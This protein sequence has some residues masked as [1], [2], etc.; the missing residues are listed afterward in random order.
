V[1]C[2]TQEEVDELGRKLS[3]GGEEQMCG[4]LK[5]TYGL[6]GKCGTKTPRRPG[7]VHAGDA[8]DADD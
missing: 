3:D 4:W 7:R 2:D 1:N 6:S 8:S 5:D